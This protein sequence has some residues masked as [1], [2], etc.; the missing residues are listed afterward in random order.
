MNNVEALQALYAA[1]GGEPAD[2]AN[3]STSVEV[4]NAI[5]AKFDG[6]DD[7][8][9]NPDAIANIA[10]V[11]GDVIGGNE[12][13]VSLIDRSITQFTI[14]DGVTQIGASAFQGC[15]KLAQITIPDT[16]TSIGG[17]AFQNCYEL[18]EITIPDTITSIG[19]SAFQNCRKVTEIFIPASVDGIGN[20]AFYQCSALETIT[21][22]KPS[23]SIPGSPWGA[24]S[25][26]S[27]VWAS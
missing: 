17:A 6:E 27:I 13:L 4:L 18:A 5:A 7:A 10:A 19:T 9:L 24:P 8:T 20:Q 26:T 11:I 1:L 3:V 23:G 12:E 2:V 21:I 14:P 16:V 15:T 25:T 22:D